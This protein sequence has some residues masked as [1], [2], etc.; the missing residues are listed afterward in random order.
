MRYKL[1]VLIILTD[2]AA[3]GGADAI[4]AVSSAEDGAGAVVITNADAAVKDLNAARE[5]KD[6]AISAA[7]ENLPELILTDFSRKQ[8]SKELPENAAAIDS[9]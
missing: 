9:K 7:K 1:C 4:Y 6:A 8:D 3:T 5:L 2:A